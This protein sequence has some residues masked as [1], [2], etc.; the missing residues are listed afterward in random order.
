LTDTPNGF[1]YLS[2]GTVIRTST[3]PKHI[4]DMFY[5]VLTNLPCKVL[6]K[7]DIELPNKADNIYTADWFPQQSVL[8][9]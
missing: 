9:N 7:T 5:D 3:F 1:I 4:L 6:W 8:G 2:L